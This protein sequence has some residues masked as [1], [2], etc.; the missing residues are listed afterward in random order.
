ML[1]IVD[2][3]RGNLFSIAQALGRLGVPHEI[4]GDPDRVAG[5]DGLILPGV[6]AFGDAMAELSR[7]GLV[8]PLRRAA[9]DN[10]P[11]LG[12]CV[13]CQ[14]L[15]E[16]GREFGEHAGLGLLKGVV[17]RLAEPEPADGDWRIPNVGWR[18]LTPTRTDSIFAD[19]DPKAMVYFVHS[20]VMRVED[21]AVLAATFSFSGTAVPAAVQVGNLIGT[22]FHMERS[23]PVGLELLR[24]FTALVR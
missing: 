2:Y 14:V 18:P 16:S 1:A 23:G 19:M 6:G 8:E 22:Q 21:P 13:G 4:T 20:F 17:E 10:R 5:A 9:A 24:R 11:F 7:R 15:F 12:I 3:G